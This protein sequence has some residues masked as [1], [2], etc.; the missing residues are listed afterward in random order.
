MALLAVERNEEA[1]MQQ[2]VHNLE[3]FLA[4]VAGDMQALELIVDNVGSLAVE[5]VDDLA[6]G[7]FVAGDS[8]GGDD[9]TVARLNFHLSVPGEG[10]AVQSR[11]IFALRARRNNHDLVLWKGFDGVDVDKGVV[12]N[13]EI[14][15][16][17]RDL[18]DIFH[19]AACDRDLSSV[20]VRNVQKALK[21]KGVGRK[22]CDDDPLAA[23][24]ELAVKTVGDAALRGRKARALDVC[25]VAQE[26]KHA[27]VSEL[28]QARKI[29]HAVL[30]HRVDFKIAREDERADRRFDREGHRVR[31]R[32][33]HMDELDLEAPGLHDL[34]CLVCKELDLALE[35]VLFQLELHKPGCQPR[36]MD[37]A[38]ELLHGIGNA[39]D[40]VLVAVCQ[41]H[42]ADLFLIL[43]QIRHV[44]DDKVDAVHV[45]LG[46]SEAAVDDN[47]I[48]AVF[49]NGHIFAD[50]IES[51]KGNNL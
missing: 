34:T 36:T 23:A 28:A 6:D 30:R 42:T 16:V 32:V 40:V 12:W 5:L 2:R 26:G 29:D 41:K 10:H 33:V 19:A 14:A 21:A 47:D 24:G 50:L 37:R 3:L 43:N 39:A 4:G 35:V 22:R 25:G 11:H 1:R 46:E 7:L 49:E 51:P 9:H 8:R 45:V 44:R 27:L 17:R 31:D 15:K 13:L 48:L 20:L 38:V 18:Q